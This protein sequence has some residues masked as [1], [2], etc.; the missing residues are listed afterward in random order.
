MSRFIRLPGILVFVAIMLAASGIWFLVADSVV[1]SMLEGAGT[2][3]VGARVE[4]ESAD[5]SLFPLGLELTGLRVTN[6]EKPMHNAMVADYIEMKINTG[7][8][9]TYIS[10]I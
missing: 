6:P 5:L 2:K 1:K 4:L 10:H 3:A 9:I 8:L 7:H